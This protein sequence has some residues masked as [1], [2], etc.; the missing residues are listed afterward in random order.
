MEVQQVIDYVKDGRDLKITHVQALIANL[1]GVGP[2]TVHSWMLTG[3]IPFERQCVIYYKTNQ[4][5]VPDEAI[6]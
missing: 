6:E 4:E 2:K 3:S 1:A 5:L